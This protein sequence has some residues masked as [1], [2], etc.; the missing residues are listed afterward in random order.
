MDFSENAERENSHSKGNKYLRVIHK[1]N[2]KQSEDFQ[3][4]TNSPRNINPLSRMTQLFFIYLNFA[5]AP[6]RNSHLMTLFLV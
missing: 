3:L 1:G 4:M 6:M 2:A 5:V